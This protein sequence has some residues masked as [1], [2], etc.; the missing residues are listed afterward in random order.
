MSTHSPNFIDKMSNNIDMLLMSYNKYLPEENLFIL[1]QKL[2]SMD[3]DKVRVLYSVPM[4]DPVIS[5]VL[6]LVAGYL[7]ADRFY[8]GDITLGVLKLL[9]CGGLGIWTII[10][11]FLIMKATKEKN[12][13][14]LIRFI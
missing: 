3:E 7:G 9:T 2:E 11:Y 8:I 1:R 4:K 13:T 5:L 12:L 14:K 6:S 10:D